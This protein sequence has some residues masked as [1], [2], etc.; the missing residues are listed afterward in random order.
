MS[1]DI[2]LHGPVKVSIEVSIVAK[3][4]LSAA[5]TFEMPSG[6]YPTIEDI[7][8]AQADALEMAQKEYPDARLSTAE[9]FLGDMFEGTTGSREWAGVSGRQWDEFKP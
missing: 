8:K 6:K 3:E 4:G 2:T 5:V 1:E 9:E 7:E